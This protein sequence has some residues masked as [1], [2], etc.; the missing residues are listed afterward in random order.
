MSS[1]RIYPIDVESE[2]MSD[3]DDDVSP[4][5]RQLMAELDKL[6]ADMK[7]RRDEC[8]EFLE[9]VIKWKINANKVTDFITSKTTVQEFYDFVTQ[10]GTEFNYCLNASESRCGWSALLAACDEQNVALVSALLAAGANPDQCRRDG[11]RPLDLAIAAKNEKLTSIF[12]AAGAHAGI[13]NHAEDI[14]HYREQLREAVINNDIA[15]ARKLLAEHQNEIDLLSVPIGYDHYCTRQAV[16]GGN[17][18]LV[19]LLVEHGDDYIEDD[20][21]SGKSNITLARELGCT[22]IANYLEQRQRDVYQKLREQIQV[23]TPQATTGTVHNFFPAADSSASLLE[24]AD[25]VLA[26]AYKVVPR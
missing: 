23:K 6:E 16:M 3:S 14:V 15:A 13:D 11:L 7:R 22:E 24:R 18:E 25:N 4:Q 20:H 1:T 21:M 26:L 10:D 5:E 2:V 17:L 8:D 19:K 9:P 12:Q